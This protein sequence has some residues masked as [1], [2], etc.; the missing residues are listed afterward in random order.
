MVEYFKKNFTPIIVVMNTIITIVTFA[1]LPEPPPQYFCRQARD[2]N[3]N[4]YDY[5][6]CNPDNIPNLPQQ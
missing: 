2:F 6:I 3:G 5:M 1:K 4:L